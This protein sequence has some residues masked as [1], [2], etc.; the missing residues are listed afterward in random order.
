MCL[1]MRKMLKPLV[2]KQWMMGKIYVSILAGACTATLISPLSE[3]LEKIKSSLYKVVHTY[4]SVSRFF[5]RGTEASLVEEALSLTD[6][7]SI[8]TS[9]QIST[10]FI[11]SI[12]VY[13]ILSTYVD[14]LSNPHLATLRR[15][16]EAWPEHAPWAPQALRDYASPLFVEYVQRGP[17][18][19]KEE[20]LA[21]VFLLAFDVFLTKEIYSLSSMLHHS[22]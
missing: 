3:R 14:H 2:S 21:E 5:E 19:I 9:L 1:E 15:F 20:E 16:L 11:T 18:V 4:S 17:S 7:S 12:A 6:N 22:P 13:Y 10:F 8:L